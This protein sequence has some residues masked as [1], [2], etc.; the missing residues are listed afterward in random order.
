[1]CG[2]VGLW[3]PKEGWVQNAPTIIRQL[4]FVDQLRGRDAV[5]VFGERKKYEGVDWV[6]MTGPADNF[7]EWKDANDRFLTW[8]DE[9][10]FLV[11][12]NRAAT[13]GDRDDTKAAHPHATKNI[14]LVHNGTLRNYPDRQKYVS[15]SAWIAHALEENPDFRE[16]EKKFFGAFVVVWWDNRNKTL[17]FVRNTERPLG[18][19]E[20]TNGHVWFASEPKMLEWVLARNGKKIKRLFDLPER[21]WMRIDEKNQVEEIEVPFTTGKPHW[22]GGKRITVEVA[23]YTSETFLKTPEA[24]RAQETID[25]GNAAVKSFE[26]SKVEVNPIRPT[27]AVSAYQHSWPGV[28]VQ[29]SSSGS[30]Q[31]S[32]HL[33]SPSG[34]ET[35]LTDNKEFL[36]SWSGLEKG[37]KIEFFPM[38]KSTT[39]VQNNRIMLAGPM[40]V[41]NQKGQVEFPHGVEVRGRLCGKIDEDLS[42]SVIQKLDMLNEMKC[43]FEATITAFA[44]DNKRKRMVIWVKEAEPCDWFDLDTWSSDLTE[45]EKAWRSP[46]VEPAAPEVAAKEAKKIRDSR[47]N[48][49]DWTTLASVEIAKGVYLMRPVKRVTSRSSAPSVNSSSIQSRTMSTSGGSAIIN[50]SNLPSLPKLL[51][52][53]KKY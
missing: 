28:G 41:F 30:H 3:N 23:K 22:K 20:D 37:V 1:M 46:F 9:F 52:L 49:L 24:K 2:I 25:G 6:K 14:I 29:R 11:L 27:H 18:F 8:A 36:D 50:E 31:N 47:F 38:E 51:T 16:V 10:R 4:L 45:V 53:T 5:G 44:R 15:D 13:I 17:N 40:M 34:S 12:H 26:E 21:K 35:S 7:L 48:Y 33:N 32:E 39:G 19:I 43:A 42:K